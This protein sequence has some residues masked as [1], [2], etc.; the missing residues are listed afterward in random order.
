MLKKSIF[1]I[2]ILAILGI[3]GFASN[4]NAQDGNVCTTGACEV[5]PATVDRT[6]SV[7]TTTAQT[8]TSRTIESKS[9]KAKV[10]HYSTVK[11]VRVTIFMNP[12][13][14]KITDKNADDCDDPVKK[15]WIKPGQ[16]FENTD[17]YNK[18]FTDKWKRKDAKTGKIIKVCYW[19]IVVIDGVRYIEGTKSNC[20]NKKI[21]IRIGGRKR[22]WKYVPVKEFRSFKEFLAVYNKWTSSTTTTSTT[23]T[24]SV[25]ITYSCPAGWTPIEN[26]QKCQKCPKPECVKDGS[27]TPPT[28][29]QAPGPNPEPSPNEPYPGGYACYDETTG[30]PVEPI[31]VNDVPMCPAGSYGSPTRR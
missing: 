1:G 21:R 25:K 16:Y 18:R 30:A 22:S 6:T 23:S 15:G 19:K 17:D 26:G 20:K 29:P 7:T 11:R 31:Y 8:T 14:L 5:I 10:R 9:K 3:L 4:A 12:H 24:P 28:P 27:T 2:V 13:G